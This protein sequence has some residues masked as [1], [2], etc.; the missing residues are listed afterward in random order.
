[1]TE[2]TRCPRCNEPYEKLM[3]SATAPVFMPD[4]TELTCTIDLLKVVKEGQASHLP[5]R[6]PLCF[7]CFTSLAQYALAK[8]SREYNKAGS[9]PGVTIE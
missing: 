6:A 8:I 1:M 2:I 3:W 5:L 4:G 7:S 9:E